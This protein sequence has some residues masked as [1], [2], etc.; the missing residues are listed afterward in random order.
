MSLFNHKSSTDEKPEPVWFVAEL[1]GVGNTSLAHHTRDAALNDFTAA[2]IYAD[3][4]GEPYS[5]H[6]RLRR[7]VATGPDW[8]KQPDDPADPLVVGDAAVRS[9]LTA[10]EYRLIVHGTV[11][12]VFLES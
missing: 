8:C 4:A 5:P 7:L 6:D 3:H 1:G 12:A 9:V 10:E 11:A 2:L